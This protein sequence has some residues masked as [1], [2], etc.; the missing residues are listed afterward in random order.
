MRSAVC[1]SLSVCVCVRATVHLWEDLQQTMCTNKHM[2]TWTH[3]THMRHANLLIK[4]RSVLHIHICR[5]K[6]TYTQTHTHTHT[7]WHSVSGL[8]N[9]YYP[10]SLYLPTDVPCVSPRLLSIPAFPSPSLIQACPAV[11]SS[12]ITACP[13]ITAAER[14]KGQKETVKRKAETENLHERGGI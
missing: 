7:G 10:T 11:T 4:H 12:P 13:Q 1:V 2:H 14:L 8:T 9:S 5:H 6:G 3:Y